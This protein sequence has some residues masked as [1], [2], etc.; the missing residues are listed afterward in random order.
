MYMLNGLSKCKSNLREKEDNNAMSELMVNSS[1]NE[2]EDDATESMV[3]KKCLPS[4][5]LV[6]PINSKTH[7]EDWSLN[8]QSRFLPKIRLVSFLMRA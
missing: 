4:L 6:L 1:C 5:V 3:N 8:D 2:N 7:K